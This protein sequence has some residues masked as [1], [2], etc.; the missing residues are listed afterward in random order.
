MQH[1]RKN[2]LYALQIDHLLRTTPCLPH[3][4]VLILFGTIHSMETSASPKEM[5]AYACKEGAS[6]ESIET[7]TVDRYYADG[8]WAAWGTG[9]SYFVCDENE[10]AMYSDSCIS[11]WCKPH[12]NVCAWNRMFFAMS[13]SSFPYMALRFRHSEL[14]KSFI[15]SHGSLK[16]LHLL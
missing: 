16:T 12:P 9:Q 8:K 4:T 14:F 5:P 6:E 3:H 13:C 7:L 15:Q 11:I 1:H 2:L 10:R